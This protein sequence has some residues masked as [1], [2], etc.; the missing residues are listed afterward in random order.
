[1][2]LFE[3][4]AAFQVATGV[5]RMVRDEGERFQ[6]EVEGLGDD[7]TLGRDRAELARLLAYR[8][9]REDEGEA[10][11]ARSRWL[12][13]HNAERS[14]PCGTVPDPVVAGS[15]AVP[16]EPSPPP[17]VLLPSDPGWA[18][19]ESPTSPRPP[20]EPDGGAPIRPM[21]VIAAVLRNDLV[22]IREH[23]DDGEVEEVGR[24]PREAIQEVDVVNVQG[25]HVPDPVRETIE[26]EEL[27]F[28][29]LRWSNEGTP[30]EDRFLFRSPW[31]AWRAGRKLLE[32]RQG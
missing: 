10:K 5:I 4:F 15:G 26:P 16:G 19:P 6:R 24:L 3:W 28:A 25:A 13:A 22:F 29:V 2:P 12:E 20:P 14:F 18:A 23:T 27:V 8:P 1:M 11:L 17:R 9:E 30:D 21:Q 7:V 31:L 32:A